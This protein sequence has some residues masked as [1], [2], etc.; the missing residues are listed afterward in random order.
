MTYGRV[1]VL[2]I[3]ATRLQAR[4]DVLRDYQCH[5]NLAK[6]VL[7]RSIPEGPHSVLVDARAIMELYLRERGRTEAKTW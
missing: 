5:K 6:C 2:D 7:G 4:H 1:H 3:C